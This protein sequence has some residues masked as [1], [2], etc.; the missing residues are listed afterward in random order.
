M[1]YDYWKRELHGQELP[2][3]MF[4]ENFTIQGLLEDS[5]FLGD[6]LAV[7][8]A[9][10]VVTQPRLPCYKLGIRFGSDDMVKRFFASKRSGFYVAVTRE[11]EVGANDEIQLIARDPNKVPVSEIMRLYAAKQYNNG[12]LDSLRRM[13]KIDAVPDSWKNYFRERVPDVEL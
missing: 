12:D 3:G 2:V 1:H 13:M 10:L 4:G 5:L 8:S 6:R 9:E 7:G 11:G